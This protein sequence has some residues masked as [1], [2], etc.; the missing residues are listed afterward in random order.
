MFDRHGNRKNKH[1]ARLRFLWNRLGE[2]SFRNLYEEESRNL[3]DVPLDAVTAI[4]NKA[5]SSAGDAV[6]TY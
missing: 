3:G 6:W 5:A 2:E 1:A 4:A